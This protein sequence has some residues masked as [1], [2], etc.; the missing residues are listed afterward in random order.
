MRHIIEGVESQKVNF[1]GYEQIAII[2]KKDGID[3]IKDVL[4]SE[5]AF[6][7]TREY[8]RGIGNEYE[9]WVPHYFVS[10]EETNLRARLKECWGYE[11]IQV[12][13]ESFEEL[14]KQAKKDIGNG[15]PIIIACDLYDLP[16]FVEYHN[17]HPESP[18]YIMVY[19]FDEENKEIFYY[20]TTRGFIEGPN[21]TASFEELNSI[22]NPETNLFHLDYSYLT[23][24]KVGDT[25]DT[26]EKEHL[27]HTA[28]K[29]LDSSVIKGQGQITYCGIGGIRKL[30]EEF[31]LINKWGN[32][33]FLN[34]YKDK[35]E[36]MIALVCQQRNG[37]YKKFMDKKNELELEEGFEEQLRDIYKGWN[38]LK[39]CMFNIRKQEVKTLFEKGAIL[40]FEIAEKE[41][42]FLKEIFKA[43]RESYGEKKERTYCL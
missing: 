5:W 23:I 43:R 8:G 40:L 32:D 17:S 38:A 41:E 18:H 16:Y 15:H 39:L 14:L 2:I 6:S 20:D 13:K 27:L 35:L 12:R 28:K 7:F 30:A 34:Q 3:L 1:C 29:M 19:G 37:N 9:K 25:K 4:G 21:H 22:L 31:E 11:F 10:S 33:V 26:M 42:S 24:K 36:N